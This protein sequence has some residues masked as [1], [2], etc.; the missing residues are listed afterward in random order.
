MEA[1]AALADL[2]EVSSQVEAAVLVDGAGDVLAA[3]IADEERARRLAAIA[4][5]LLAAADAAEPRRTPVRQLEAATGNG[6]VFVVRDARGS[7]IVATTSSAA[8]SGLVFYDLKTCLRA[9]AD[10]GA[11]A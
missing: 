5:E 4:R 9:L 11:P 3:T 10:D 8:I 6:S 7:A 2:M 1:E